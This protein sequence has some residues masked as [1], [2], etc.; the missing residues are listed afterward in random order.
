MPRAEKTVFPGQETSAKVLGHTLAWPIQ[1]TVRTLWCWYNLSVL[2]PTPVWLHRIQAQSPCSREAPPYP[3]WALTPH[4]GHY[5]L[6]HTCPLGRHA[7]LTP[8]PKS[9]SA[10]QQSPSPAHADVYLAGFYLWAFVLNYWEGR[11]E[12]KQVGRKTI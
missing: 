7:H 11:Q 2:P 10:F 3:P 5:F 4:L 6:L 9:C 1:G 12:C 8:L